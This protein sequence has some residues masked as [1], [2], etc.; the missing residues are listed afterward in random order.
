MEITDCFDYHLFLSPP[1]TS[2]N[3]ENN[4]F[5]LTITYLIQQLVR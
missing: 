3:S 5:N 4:W 1:K 2:G